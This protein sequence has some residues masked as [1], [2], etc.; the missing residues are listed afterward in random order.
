LF[1]KVF[2]YLLFVI[3]VSIRT[4]FNMRH[5]SVYTAFILVV[6]PL[7]WGLNCYSDPSDLSLKEE[8]G[9]HTGCIKKF[10]TK[11]QKTIDRGCFLVPTD[12]DTKC[13]T[14][15]KTGLGVCYCTTDL[16]NG[17][18]SVMYTGLGLFLPL[19]TYLLVI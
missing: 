16:C 6:I 11:T 9:M 18:L 17:G 13:F 19:L 2:C 12:G 10:M 5:L 3:D 1:F 8:C 15:D 4:C 7:A 14:E